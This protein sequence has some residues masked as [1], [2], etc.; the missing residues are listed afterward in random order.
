MTVYSQ[1][2]WCKYCDEYIDVYPQPDGPD[3]IR[4]YQLPSGASL[5][6][7]LIDWLDYKWD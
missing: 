7:K 6:V 2:W 5:V 1:S 4:L 3:G